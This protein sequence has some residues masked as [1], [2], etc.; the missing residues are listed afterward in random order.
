MVGK[1]IKE[2]NSLRKDLNLSYSEKEIS[3]G[4]FIKAIE[5]D[6]EDTF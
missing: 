5:E 4:A 3:S 1:L 2:Y 6:K